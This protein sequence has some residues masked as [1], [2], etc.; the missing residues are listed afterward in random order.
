MAQVPRSK[1]VNWVT[2]QPQIL[3]GLLISVIDPPYNAKGDGVTDDIAAINAAILDVSAAGGGTLYFPAGTY[4]MSSSLMPVSNVNLQGAGPDV[5]T[6]K[7]TLTGGPNPNNITLLIGSTFTGGSHLD[8]LPNTATTYLVNSPTEGTNTVTTTTHADAGNFS[9]G[10][11]VIVSGDA[12]GTSWWFSSWMT[13]VVSA[14]AS[15]GIIMLEEN[16]PVGGSRITRVQGLLALTQNIKVSDMTILGTNNES[17]QVLGA[18]NIVLDNIAIR[19]GSFGGTSGASHSF[20]GSRNCWMRNSVSYG[21]IL[22]VLGCF[23]GGL[24]NNTLNS[25]AIAVDGG[26][27]DVLVGGNTVNDPTDGNGNNFHGIYLPGYTRRVRVIGNTIVNVNNSFFAGISSNG[28]I[29]GDGNHI[30]I[31]NTITGANTTTPQGVVLDNSVNNTIVGNWLNNLATGGSLS[32][33]STGNTVEANTF[34]GVTTRYQISSDSSIREPFTA[35]LF[36]FTSN[37]GATPSVA[38][39][40]TFQ[41][42]NS[43]PQNVTNFTGGVSGQEIIVQFGDSNTTLIVSG[44]LFHLSG[45]INYNPP[46]NTLMKFVFAFDVWYELSRVTTN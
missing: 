37:A 33:G 2:N 10:Q 44:G 29:A 15:T 21:V 42:V 28:S 26:S 7:N 8:Q 20:A 30:I 46:V 43:S 19:P 18:R 17:I 16:L 38:D 23:G 32:N 45:G 34:V 24:I 12:H 39:G 11:T 1:F 3:G 22:D 13:T 25:G 41:I 31:G 9:A 14:N 5:T 35:G 40:H 4:A 27:Q 6:I 36:K